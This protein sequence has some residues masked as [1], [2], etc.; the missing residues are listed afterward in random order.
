MLEDLEVHFVVIE[1]GVGVEYFRDGFIDTVEDLLFLSSHALHALFRHEHFKIK[2]M[3]KL[4]NKSVCHLTSN[5][6][7]SI[8]TSKVYS[9]VNHL[10]SYI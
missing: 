7:S 3:F 2:M 1:I 10:K 9:T 4:N 8:M 6:V 5:P